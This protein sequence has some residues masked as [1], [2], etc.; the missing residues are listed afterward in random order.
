[1]KAAACRSAPRAST[2]QVVGVTCVTTPVLPVWM[3]GLPAAT[4]V[5]LVRVRQVNQTVCVRV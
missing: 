3:Q 2:S 5:T 4:A 1:M